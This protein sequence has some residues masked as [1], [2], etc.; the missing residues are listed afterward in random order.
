MEP[1]SSSRRFAA[2]KPWTTRPS[3]C[4]AR[5][6]T[7]AAAPGAGWPTACDRRRLRHA[8]TSPA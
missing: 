5:S 7:A 6:R 2:H 3:I 4:G 8:R 1:P